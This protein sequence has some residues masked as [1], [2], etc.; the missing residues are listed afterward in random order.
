M[1]FTCMLIYDFFSL[2]IREPGNDTTFWYQRASKK[3]ISSICRPS[4][5]CFDLSQVNWLGHKPPILS[6]HQRGF[7]LKSYITIIVLLWATCVPFIFCGVQQGNNHAWQLGEGNAL[8]L[9]ENHLKRAWRGFPWLT[10]NMRRCVCGDS[11]G[12]VMNVARELVT[13]RSYHI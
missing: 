9:C 10:S 7:K 5:F 12:L 4:E 13:W 2:T 3:L 8:E 1:C 11:Y 6:P